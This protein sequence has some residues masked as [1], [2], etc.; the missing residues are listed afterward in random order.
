MENGDLI[1]GS[2][3][4][5]PGFLSGPEPMMQFDHLLLE[6]SV[7]DHLLRVIRQHHSEPQTGGG[8]RSDIRG[9]RCFAWF[10]SA[11]QN[12]SRASRSFESDLTRFSKKVEASRTASFRGQEIFLI[13]S[14][15]VPSPCPRFQRLHQLQARVKG[16]NVGSEHHKI[17]HVV[18]VVESLQ[19][20]DHLQSLQFLVNTIADTRYDGFG[21]FADKFDLLSYLSEKV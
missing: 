18:S 11:S 5:I 14:W 6:G 3:L 15:D 21:L 2:H 4:S 16:F 19:L 7:L 20:T 17:L 8:Q 1:G 12:V 10:S 9:T 13:V